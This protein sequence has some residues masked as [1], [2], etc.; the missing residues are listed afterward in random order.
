LNSEV[1]LSP[2][3][4]TDYVDVSVVGNNQ[5]VSIQVISLEGKVMNTRTKAVDAQTTRID[6]SS[7]STGTYLAQ[8]STDNGTVTKKV[9]IQ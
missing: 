6:V 9:V 3:P 4:S 7:L 2:N 5:V 1:V 8:L